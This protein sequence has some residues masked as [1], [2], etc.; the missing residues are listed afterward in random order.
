MKSSQ[1][2]ILQLSD[3][4]ISLAHVLT[5][6]MTI[7]F[8]LFCRAESAIGSG[9]VHGGTGKQSCL[10]SPCQPGMEPNRC[11]TEIVCLKMSSSICLSLQPQLL[12]Y[13]FGPCGTSF[14]GSCG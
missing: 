9:V 3:L 11:E 12:F 6:E 1:Y 2:Q 4:C 5:R 8:L 13:W 14:L 7:L 10:S